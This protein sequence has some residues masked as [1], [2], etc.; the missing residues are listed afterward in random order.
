MD[1]KSMRKLQA[2]QQ[3]EA[4][5]KIL[6][7]R[8]LEDKARERLNNIRVVNPDFAEQLEAVLIQLIQTRKVAKIDEATLIGIIK[9]MK[10]EKRET[11]IRR[12]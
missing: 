10:G 5:K 12:M 7:M 3:F 4:L 2:Q 8:I 1:E 6:F 11:T 9:Q